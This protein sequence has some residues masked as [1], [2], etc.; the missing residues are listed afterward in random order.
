MS[1]LGTFYAGDSVVHYAEVLILNSAALTCSTFDFLDFE[2]IEAPDLLFLFF[3]HLITG[4]A[5]YSRLGGCSVNFR[6]PV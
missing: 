5:Q 1:F 2:E 3:V 6:T 4:I